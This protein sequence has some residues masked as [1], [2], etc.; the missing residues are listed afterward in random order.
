M[1]TKAVLLITFNRPEY[2]EKVIR[3]LRKSRIKKLYIANDGPRKNNI[4]DQVNCGKVRELVKEI[5]WECEIITNFSDVNRGCKNGVVYAIDWFFENEEDGII[6]ED[7][8][9]PH[10]EFFAFCGLMLDEYK[11]EEKIK[12]VLGFNYYGQKVTSNSYFIYEGFYPWGWAT[13]R[14][15]WREYKVDSFKIESLKKMKKERH[16]HRHLYN[17]LILNL[18]LVKKDLL[19]TWDYQFVYM[20]AVKRGLSIAPYANLTKNIGE[21]GVHSINN[22][23]NF[24]YG[25]FDVNNIEHPSNLHIDKKMNALF[26]DE[27][28]SSRTIILIKRI[29]LVLGIYREIKFIIRKLKSFK[30]QRGT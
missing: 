7:D 4:N 12:A 15:V 29:L 6:I 3:C 24:E 2:T 30:N 18:S 17:S 22:K 19:D 14:R 26:L 5:D 25:E 23:L 16:T 8:I 21:N 13:W 28:S 27:H 10:E 9:I 20:M 1:K 11:N